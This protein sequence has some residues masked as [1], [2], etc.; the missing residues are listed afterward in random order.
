MASCTNQRTSLPFRVADID[1]DSLVYLLTK[2]LTV[3]SAILCEGAF[4]VDQYRF[5]N[6]VSNKGTYKLNT[7]T[8]E[9]VWDSPTTAG[10]YSAAVRV[11]EW[12]V[13]V[14]IS[15]SYVETFIRVQDKLGVSSPIPPYEPAAE[16]AALI[17]GIDTDTEPGLV[18][19][20]SPNPVQS[21]FVA[22]LKANKA[23]TAQLQLLDLSGRIV[24]HK[25][26][27]RPTIDHETTFLIEHLPAGLYVL[28]AN[29]NGQV[30]SQ[31]V[32]KQ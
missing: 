24:A 29:V 2:P 13:G 8:G 6:A 21:Q 27:T 11:Q 15:E 26:L 7:R 9:L 23:I 1:G 4:G 3:R 16:S 25:A 19:T 10:Q 14:L 12:R 5:P 32:V 22:R 30:L 17:T 20:V 31:K 28:K 18:L